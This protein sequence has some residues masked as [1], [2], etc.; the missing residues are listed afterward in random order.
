VSCLSLPDSEPLPTGLFQAE[1]FQTELFQTGLFQ[2]EKDGGKT[3]NYDRPEPVG[4]SI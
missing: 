4:Q 2:T 3:A 1:L